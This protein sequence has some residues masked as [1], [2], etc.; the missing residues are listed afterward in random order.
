MK[1]V[2]VIG[3]LHESNTFASTRTT[4]QNFEESDFQ[5][6]EEIVAR[7]GDAYHELGG[8]LAGCE[9]QGLEAVPI[10][11]AWATPSGTV[12]RQ[13]Y[14]DILGEIIDR[15]KDAGP[16]DGVLLA[17]HGAMTVEGLESG[18][19]ETVSRIRGVIG[20]NLPLVLSL[21]HHANISAPMGVE[22]HVTIAYRTYPHVDQRDRGVESARV[23]RGLVDGK[24]D[25]R[26]TLIK[27]PL[28][29]HIVRQFTSDGAMKRLY[30][31]L[32]EVVV[33]PG[34]VSASIAPGYIYADV[35]DMGV[36]V[37]VSAN[38]DQALADECARELAHLAMSLRG[39]LNAALP[40]AEEAVREAMT[41]DGTVSLMD[42][43]DNIG[44]GG[45]GDSTILFR[46]VLRQGGGATCVV[47][48]DPKAAMECFNGGIGARVTLRVGD[49]TTHEENERLVIEGEV[50]GLSDG[51]FTETQARHG[52]QRYFDQGRTAIIRT[53]DGHT[54]VLNSLRV[55]P[56]SLEQL[57][58]LEL[59]PRA[60]RMIIVKG[61]TAP[62]AAY[63]PVSD[64]V[65]AV[66]TPGITQAGPET[67]EYKNRPRPLF[68]LDEL[69]GEGEDAWKVFRRPS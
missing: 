11:A 54:V 67:F 2:A 53:V 58:S 55:M 6:G 15:L 59:D 41:V 5:V 61:A 3:F 65:I 62:R 23:M 30:D 39:D 63:E 12:E 38:G 52:G 29:I 36:S 33:R 13:A 31:G 7:W 4:K 8:F 44:G 21:D 40:S 27:L 37:V 57:L 43:G 34:I 46:E 25:A 69:E 24:V 68:P 20:A 28:L 1:R 66:D 35:P 60:F 19:G 32:E 56:T 64:R 48:H 9:E 26:Q 14:E 16:V 50:V 17:L 45:P 10:L 51:L 18:D 47:L 49:R 22:P 42:C